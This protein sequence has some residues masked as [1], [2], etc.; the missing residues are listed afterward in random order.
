MKRN[1]Y[2]LGFQNISPMVSDVCTLVI[3]IYFRE[4]ERERERE[5]CSCYKSQKM[6]YQW[7]N[8]HP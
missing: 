4:R 3:E 8:K 6:D 5:R 7:L 2:Q 1:I